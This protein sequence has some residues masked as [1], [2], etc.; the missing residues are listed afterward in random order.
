MS[1]EQSDW[2]TSAKEHHYILA[3]NVSDGY[4]YHDTDSEEV[5]FPSGTIYDHITD[6]WDYAYIGDGEYADHEEILSS[7]INKALR[8]LNGLV[9]LASLV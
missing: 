7:Q 5:K 1:I 2:T 9:N 4:W 3:Y 8:Q 6:E